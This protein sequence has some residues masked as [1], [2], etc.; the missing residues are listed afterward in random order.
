MESFK[1]QNA[2]QIF[3]AL[4]NYSKAVCGATDSTP[5]RENIQGLRRAIQTIEDRFVC[6]GKF[7]LEC[8]H[9]N[10]LKRIQELLKGAIKRKTKRHDNFLNETL[11]GKK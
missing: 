10:D 11:R 9:R 3:D 8:L 1:T 7:E 4:L 6:E 2:N 5:T